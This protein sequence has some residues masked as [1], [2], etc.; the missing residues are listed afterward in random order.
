M[1]LDHHGWHSHPPNARLSAHD[2]GIEGD[3]TEKFLRLGASITL[4][5]RNPISAAVLRRDDARP[6]SLPSAAA[7]RIGALLLDGDDGPA[8]VARK[9][10]L[11]TLACCGF[12]LLIVRTDFHAANATGFL[13]T[14]TIGASGSHEVPTEDPRMRLNSNFGAMAAAV[15]L[16]IGGQAV[17][18]DAVQWR[19]VDGGNGHWYQIDGLSPLGLNWA[20]A[21][22]R[23]V[24]RGAHLASITS[25]AE[26]S[27]LVAF[28]R[29]TAAPYGTFW[30]GGYRTDSN[31]SPACFTWTT[32][33]PWSFE[34]WGPS[35]EP[36]D[37]WGCWNPNPNNCGWSGPGTG[38]AVEFI[39][40]GA[41]SGLWN[42]ETPN[43]IGIGGAAGAPS[44]IEWSADC[45]NDGIVDY[46]QILAGELADANHNNIPDCCEVG[47]GCA[48]RPIQWRAADGG[49]DH[50][51]AGYRNA[52]GFT[53]T[54]ARGFASALSGSL[55][56]CETNQE[57][58]F[59]IAN[60]GHTTSPSLWEVQS[61]NS[62]A[63]MGPWI[64]AS[65]DQ[66]SREP[67]GGWH[68]LSGSPLN[69]QDAPN[70]CGNDCSGV[71]EDRLHLYAQVSTGWTVG[72]NDLTDDPTP[73]SHL[74]V[75]AIVEF[76]ADCNN[77][78]LVDYGQIL[79]GELA[80]ANLNNIPDCCEGGA[81]CNPCPGDVDNSG[82]V[83][84]VDLAAILNTWG[85]GGGKYP[86]ADV[87]H[88]GIVNGTDLAEVLNGWGP[89]H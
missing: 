74:L 1:A 53:W 26:N 42:D 44:I 46:G 24:A 77:D 8:V 49:N 33:E 72:W 55:V 38:L 71:Q 41:Y 13:A 75:G 27:Y 60:Y 45:N 47:A 67:N 58:Q 68:W 18:Q 82:A 80:D 30:I 22:S 6:H 50:W 70:C 54:A 62:D 63:K 69:P 5:M 9:G 15:A 37:S 14:P 29:A 84:G 28:A 11:A 89:C 16:S 88:D 7:Q 66:G 3:A 61:I 73:C 43:L 48:I 40:W 39:T 86:G 32:G 35:G 76:S 31:C 36:F 19:V 21:E 56:S 57:R 51:Y 4:D 78:G 65:Q 52:S 12:F 64:G 17:A 81:S 79:A 83:N 10:A 2:G 34:N 59:V 87:N 20:D 25:A 23:A 85:T